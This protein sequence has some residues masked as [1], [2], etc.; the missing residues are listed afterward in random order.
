MDYTFDAHEIALIPLR[1]PL[2]VRIACALEIQRAR[3]QAGVLAQRRY[4]RNVGRLWGLAA[5]KG[6]APKVLRALNCGDRS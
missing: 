6:L 3:L 2:A 1:D 5:N 4:Q